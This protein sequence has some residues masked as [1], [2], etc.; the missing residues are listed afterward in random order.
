M[1][2]NY[3]TVIVTDPALASATGL[4]SIDFLKDPIKPYKKYKTYNTN[5]AMI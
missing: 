5:E 2:S 3:P 1:M 4:P